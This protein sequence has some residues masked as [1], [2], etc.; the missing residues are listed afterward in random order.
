MDLKGKKAL[1]FGV[2]NQKSIAYSI[3]KKLKEQGVELGFTY[4]G[5]QLQRRVE[6][7]SEELGGA[8]CVKCDVTDDADIEK[9]FKTVQDKFGQIDI[10]V[11][12]VAYAPADDLK[13][14]F[15][16]TTREGFKTAMEI[17]VFSLVNL[18]KHAEPFM[19]E[20]STIIT[21]TYYGSEKVVKNYNVMGVAKAALE[22]S[23]RYLANELGE[24][25][26]RVNAISAGPIKTLAA[27]GISGFKTIL[28]RIEEKSPLRRNVTGDDVAN[29]SLYLCSE[30][31]RGV[32]GEVI[33]VD[34]GYNIVG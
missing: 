7:L 19:S 5:E 10:L 28:A 24:K 21:M 18:A 22:S 12:A 25:G 13:G 33:Y 3:A 17:S 14:R 31:S 11:H 8:F 30:L 27:S 2:A 4:A 23:V 15:V 16:D 6:P 20:G 34:S 9:T 1:I 26:I 29:T 32:T